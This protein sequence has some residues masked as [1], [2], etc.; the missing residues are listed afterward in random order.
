MNKDIE[1]KVVSDIAIAAIPSEVVENGDVIWNIYFINLKK[2]TVE[3]VLINARGGGVVDGEEKKTSTLRYFLGNM[4]AR[5][6]KKFELMLPESI[7]LTNQYWVSFFEE[8][9]MLDKKYIFPPGS[10]NS[11]LLKIVPIINQL[12]VFLE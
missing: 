4:E 7:V 6:F 8:G 11:Q 9:N 1:I 2:S 12:G 10:I 5:S 3:N